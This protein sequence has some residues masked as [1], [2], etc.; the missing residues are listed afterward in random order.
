MVLFSKTA[1][2]IGGTAKIFVKFFSLETQ[3]LRTWREGYS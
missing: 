1:A 2:L 3:F